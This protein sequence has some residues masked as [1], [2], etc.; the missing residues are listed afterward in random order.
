MTAYQKR[1]VQSFEEPIHVMMEQLN[2]QLA[3]Q[4]PTKERADEIARRISGEFNNPMTSWKGWEP[5]RAQTESY[6]KAV[7]RSAY[8]TMAISDLTI[9]AMA[10]GTTMIAERASEAQAPAPVPPARRAKMI[11]VKPEGKYR[12]VFGNWGMESINY[13]ASVGDYGVKFQKDL[14]VTASLMLES[15]RLDAVNPKLREFEDRF[16]DHMYY[17]RAEP[18][19]PME[20]LPSGLK[21]VHE[22]VEP[23]ASTATLTFVDAVRTYYEA[24]TLLT[25]SKVGNLSGPELVRKILEAPQDGGP[26]LLVQFAAQVPPQLLPTWTRSG[27]YFPEPLELSP[28][29]ALTLSPKFKEFLKKEADAVGQRQPD[30]RG[31][32]TGRGCP[33]VRKLS[34]GR[35]VI[36]DFG[37]AYLQVYSRVNEGT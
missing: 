4:P 21:R 5:S 24:L 10:Q 34:N 26:S 22:S 30:A 2:N 7:Y 18:D 32:E 6:Y 23:V 14:A 37:H 29:G 1:A 8:N 33:F 15:L 25:Q 17:R 19:G 20:R 31:I 36:N 35:N 16:V 3:N 12:D 11:V 27:G 13:L 28:S 9:D